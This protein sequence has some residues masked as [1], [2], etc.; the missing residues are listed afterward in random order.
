MNI[1]PPP[2]SVLATALVSRNNNFIGSSE[3]LDMNCD[4]L[5]YNTAYTGAPRLRSFFPYNSDTHYSSLQNAIH[6]GPNLDILNLYEKIDIKYTFY[7]INYSL[8]LH[9]D[10][11]VI[12]GTR[13]TMDVYSHTQL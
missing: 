11:L 8:I 3:T 6:T 13:V 12:R 4:I 9:F 1:P 10:Y 7:N 5:W 2:I